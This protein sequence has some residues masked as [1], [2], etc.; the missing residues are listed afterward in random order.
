M[1]IQWYI[2]LT[3]LLDIIFG[4]KQIGE[5][6]EMA[7]NVYYPLCYEEEVNWDEVNLPL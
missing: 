1:I 7:D 5:Q 3:T 6:A 2:N 4:Y